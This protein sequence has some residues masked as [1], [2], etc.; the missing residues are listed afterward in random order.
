MLVTNINLPY[1]FKYQ[2]KTNG[3]TTK[4]INCSHERDNRSLFIIK[5]IIQN[6]KTTINEVLLTVI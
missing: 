4:I 5:F 3:V 2:L 6:K 1:D